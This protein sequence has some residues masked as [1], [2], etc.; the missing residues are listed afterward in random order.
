[1]FPDVHRWVAGCAADE[2]EDIAEDLEGKDDPH[3]PEVLMMSRIKGTVIVV[4]IF[5]VLAPSS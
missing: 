2:G 4:N 5:Q 3:H 1:M